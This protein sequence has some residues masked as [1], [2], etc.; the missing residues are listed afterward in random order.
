MGLLTLVNNWLNIAN[1]KSFELA[2]VAR[3]GA[4]FKYYLYDK[5]LRQV[6]LLT[7]AMVLFSKKTLINIQVR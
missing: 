4:Y 7:P 6:R 1:A 3:Q 2:Y 5:S